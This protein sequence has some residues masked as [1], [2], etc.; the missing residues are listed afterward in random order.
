MPTVL[1]T[2]YECRAGRLPR[3]CA[4]CGEPTDDGVR[5]PLLTP[6]PHFLLNLFLVVCPPVFVL[7]AVTVLDRRTYLLPLCPSHRD[8]WKWR[9]RV[10]TWTYLAIPCL[11]YSTI[12]I[13]TYLSVDGAMAFALGVAVYYLS[14]AT[15]VTPAAILWT[16]AVRT[17]KV[18]A[19][20]IRLS[21]VHPTFVTALR[22]DRARDADPARLTWGG[23]ERDD[24]DD[25][26]D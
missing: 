19:R 14:W 23:T 6:V 5:V 3:L 9:D 25:P 17:S 13:L 26:A 16:H 18:T 12:P 21:G 7:L 24:Y 8:D 15:W 11:T 22:E 20:G 1:L 10:S 2:S 4:R